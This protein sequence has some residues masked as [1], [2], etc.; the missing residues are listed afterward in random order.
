M[1]HMTILD[2]ITGDIGSTI[3]PLV[4]A[5]RLAWD[6]FHAAWTKD[7]NNNWHKSVRVFLLPS[8]SSYNKYQTSQYFWGRNRDYSSYF[9]INETDCKYLAPLG[10]EPMVPYGKGGWC[11]ANNQSM[12][13]V[14][15][16]IA[17]QKG[18]NPQFL[19][20]KELFVNGV[21]IDMVITDHEYRARL[22]ASNEKPDTV[23]DYLGQHGHLGN[24]ARGAETKSCK[25]FLAWVFFGISIPSSCNV[26]E[27]FDKITNGVL[28][29][30]V[31][32][33]VARARVIVATADDIFG[34]LGSYC[35]GKSKDQ[36]L[37]MVAVWDAG[38]RSMG[39]EPP[40]RP[41]LR[42]KGIND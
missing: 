21:E 37:R 42:I 20:F 31:G 7:V 27:I 16:Q 17:K 38:L 36:L 32:R 12:E 4:E 23:A 25:T 13:A 11:S 18:V 19:D 29:A 22:D 15:T 39:V 24:K 34:P 33:D 10:L 35:R 1:D 26:G 28:P 30:I 5:R 9:S 41:D 3:D 2:E 40:V 6:L 8:K 14:F